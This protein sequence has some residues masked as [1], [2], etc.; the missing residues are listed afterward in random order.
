MTTDILTI[1]GSSGEGGGQILRTSLALALVTG[2]PFRLEKIRANRKRPGLQR[3][4]LTAVRAAAEVGQAEVRG[5]E[6]DSLELL[7]VPGE[8]RP[9]EYAFDIGTAGSVT[10]VLQTVLPALMLAPAPSQ[11]RL[12]GGTHNML[13][14]PVDFLQEAFL[15]LLNRMG[16]EIEVRLDRYGFY[17]RGGGQITASIQPAATLAR[18]DL[19]QRGRLR[20]RAAVGVVANLPRH[21]AEREVDTI[22]RRLSWPEDFLEIREV[23]SHGPGNVV[24]VTIESEQVT[25]VFTGFGQIG[26]P[27]EKVAAGVVRE[28]RRYLE[29][30]APVGEHLADQLLLPLALAGGGSYRTLELSNHTTTNIETIRRFL[31]VAVVAE[32]VQPSLWEVRLGG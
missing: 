16:P 15:P 20:R 23:E 4:H 14:P 24:Y 31:E 21:I 3:Q 32:P 28:V 7:F 10:L 22:R 27:A 18:L 17:P 30:E 6:L 2:R 19:L 11:L 26:V 12:I 8:N 13:A 9:G 5:A 25:E 29:S 1:D